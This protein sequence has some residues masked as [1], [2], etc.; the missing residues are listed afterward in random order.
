MP[1]AQKN[2]FPILID[3]EQFPALVIGGGNIAF[4]KAMSLLGFGSVVKVISPELGDEMQKLADEGKVDVTLKEYQEGD[5]GDY[6]L[7]FCATDNPEVDEAV[8]RDCD[9]AGVLL[10]VADIP[11]LCNFI[12][13]ATIKRGK[14]IAA[15]STQG[16]A[17]FYVKE[18]R[19]EMELLLSPMVA[20]VTEL[21][22]AFRRK[23]MD[24]PRFD[25]PEKRYALFHRFLDIHWEKILYDQG[26]EGAY[27][28]ME[29]LFD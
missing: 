23:L 6:K 21:A 19:E 26:R 8:R 28:K 2:Y 1:G 14:F 22:G 13:P 29:E 27:K 4:R 9:K 10:N 25:N 11:D 16:E 5:I 12:M 15:L 24:D 3:L 20:D 18:K 17:P 7:V